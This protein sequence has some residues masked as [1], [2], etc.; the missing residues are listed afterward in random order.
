MAAF[1]V[2]NTLAYQLEPAVT[3][4]DQREDVRQM[5]NNNVDCYLDLSEL[6]IVCSFEADSSH[7]SRDIQRYIAEYVAD[8][9]AD[10]LTGIV[11]EIRGLEG[12]ESDGD[13]ELIRDSSNVFWE[14]DADRSRSLADLGADLGLRLVL[15]E[16]V[17]DRVK[18]DLGITGYR[19]AAIAVAHLAYK[20]DGS[21][22]IAVSSN[23][24]TSAVESAD[25]VFKPGA[26]ANFTPLNERTKSAIQSGLTDR[27][28][29]I[30]DWF[31]SEMRGELDALVDGDLPHW[32]VHS[33]LGRLESAL[34]EDTEGSASDLRTEEA[35]RIAALVD[36][37][38]RD[39]HPP[40]ERV[41]PK[42]LDRSTKEELIAGIEADVTVERRAIEEEA[43]DRSLETLRDPLSRLRSLDRAAEI[44]ALNRARE[45]LDGTFDE[46]HDRDPVASF[47]DYADA[48]R[49]SGLHEE[50]EREELF[51]RLR[52]E[53]D[54]RLDTIVANERAD[55]F[56]WFERWLDGVTDPETTDRPAKLR[57]ARSLLDDDED[58]EGSEGWVSATSDRDDDGWG[59]V[60][61]SHDVSVPT[62]ESILE[63][64]RSSTVLSDEEK[65]T[66]QALF[67]E[68]V[69]E[70]IDRVRENERE[71]FRE[72]L[73]GYVDA[74]VV[75]DLAIEKR[76]RRLGSLRDALDART[77]PESDRLA[78]F[79]A[80]VEAL[81]SHP[82]LDDD[83][84][85]VTDAVESEIESERERLL[86]RKR[87]L[88][89]GGVRRELDRIVDRTDS[90]D[91]AQLHEELE[92]AERYL[93]GEIDEAAYPDRSYLEGL[94]GHIDE[95]DVRRSGP[96]P[97][98]TRG[99]RQRLRTTCKEY[100][101]AARRAV[102]RDRLD[103]LQSEVDE[104]IEAFREASADTE[105]KLVVVEGL[106]EHHTRGSS[107][108]IEIPND[109]GDDQIA[110]LERHYS[111]LSVFLKK[112]V[113]VE[114]VEVL[115]RDEQTELVDHFEEKLTEL[116]DALASEVADDL[117]AEIRRQYEQRVVV[118]PD[119]ATIDEIAEAIDVL[120]Y[121]E[122]EV[123]RLYNGSIVGSQYL[124]D[125]TI[126]RT[127]RLGT[128]HKGELREK[129]VSYVEEE[130]ERLKQHR[131]E[132]ARERFVDA[133]D[134]VAESDGSIEDQL[135]A[136]YGIR[137]VLLGGR[138]DEV[139]IVD[140]DALRSYREELDEDGR[141]TIKDRIEST[142]RDLLDEYERFVQRSVEGAFRA[143]YEHDDRQTGVVADT[144][145]KLLDEGEE[146]ESLSESDYLR[147]AV[148]RVRELRELKRL[149]ILGNDRYTQLYHTIHGTAEQ[150]AA[151]DESESESRFARLPSFGGDVPSVSRRTLAGAAAILVVGI[152][153]GILI[154][155]LLVSETALLGFVTS[156]G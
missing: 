3:D 154:G 68:R 2:Y 114:G 140:G 131:Q 56:E 36:A 85:T 138:P 152:L 136:L 84:R 148:E 66:I 71:R 9:P 124:Y 103:S 88:V 146:D 28:S 135:V 155:A 58:T 52:E 142:K 128:K 112:D 15:E 23:G 17:E 7:V 116:R 90:V 75:A 107:E 49:E 19:E 18:L 72:E 101:Q 78:E 127:K 41:D 67:R 16:L 121:L 53:I 45:A 123:E 110:E 37:L 82:L 80:E 5:A 76:Y 29:W 43:I 51:D 120:E 150:Y 33:E 81:R 10:L 105:N 79:A 132:I 48:I 55:L 59:A 111:Q 77:E 63:Q 69:G 129:L 137:Q 22:R 20:T 141:Q 97:I 149:P 91:H 119:T 35:S 62:L 1:R 64:L 65:P 40:S 34:S 89:D 8:D 133:V 102:R 147:P 134:R 25:L 44:E 96:D 74:V 11:R 39:E 122:S 50:A 70:E 4:P 12:P 145:L 118:D 92:T 54:D 30:R 113:T 87:K 83:A 106:L 94:K 42:I 61:D 95:L 32:S 6:R 99:E 100:L 115:Q 108:T 126:E 98:L 14:F 144:F 151:A 31:E 86:D 24:R 27:K 13:W 130:V 109:A 156:L 21:Q 26:D 104:R 73:L 117:Q 46:D 57:R 143:H 93:L 47:A 153:I 139:R 60:G 125:E 38:R